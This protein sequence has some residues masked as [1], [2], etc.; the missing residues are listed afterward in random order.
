M[1]GVEVHSG[2]HFF[3]DIVFGTAG[4]NAAMTKVRTPKPSPA[5]SLI[6]PHRATFRWERP[7]D[8]LLEQ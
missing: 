5:N 1:K 3:A 8:P 7:Q 2:F 4:I 6:P